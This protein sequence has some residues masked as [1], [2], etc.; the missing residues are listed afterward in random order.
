[1]NEELLQCDTHGLQAFSIV[2]KHLST[3]SENFGFHEVEVGANRPEAWCDACN[4]RWQL[5]NNT[6]T[7]REMWEDAC[8]FK[9]VCV[10]CYDAIKAKNELAPN[11][12]LEVFTL[13][14][15]V[16]FLDQNNNSIKENF[17]FPHF[18]SQL[19]L[20]ILSKQNTQLIA[21]ECQ[22]LSLDDAIKINNSSPKKEEWIFATSIESEYWSFTSD[23]HIMY[24]EQIE[25]NVIAKKIEISFDESLQLAFVLKKLDFIQQKYLVTVSL[26]KALQQRLQMINPKLTTYFKDII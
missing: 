19:Y 17:V 12:D 14:E 24:Y 15:I 26:Q 21:I 25:N 4:E 22:L 6:E 9:I 5:Q 8:D 23:N 7:D 1:M 13:N 10:F 2:C 11:F 16:N 18:L 20:N 3:K